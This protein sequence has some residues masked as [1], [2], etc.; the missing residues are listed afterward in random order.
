MTLA[1]PEEGQANPGFEFEGPM[2]HFWNLEEVP[3]AS[4]VLAVAECL[5]ELYR[6]GMSSDEAAEKVRAL[7]K[8]RTEW[9]R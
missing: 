2:G 8:E 6:R 9:L 1:H 7:Q 3:T 4:V 5:H